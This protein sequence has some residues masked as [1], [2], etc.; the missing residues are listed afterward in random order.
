[1]NIFNKRIRILFLTLLFFFIIVI[2]LHYTNVLLP[3][4]KYFSYIISPIQSKVYNLTIKINQL[5]RKKYSLNEL[6]KQNQSLN[7]KL[8]ELLLKQVELEELKKE[9]QIL[10]KL[11]EFEKQKKYKL[12]TA[13]IIGYTSDNLQKFFIINKGFLSGIRVGLPVIVDRGF[14]IG[15]IIKV[16]ANTSVIQL[17]TNN[18]SKIAATILN[19]DR[20]VGLVEGQNNVNMVMKLI[21]QQETIFEDNIVITS[22]IEKFI[23]RGLIIGVVDNMLT[24]KGDLFQTALIRPLIDFNK[25]TIVSVL[26]NKK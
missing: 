6:E 8:N 13:N 24:Q 12:I 19:K 4:E 3:I 17:I 11:L 26:I 21:P 14:L 2:I 7:K 5:Y 18:N 20:T 1:M 23:P 10:R 22:G 25:L 16:Q 15:K 9:N